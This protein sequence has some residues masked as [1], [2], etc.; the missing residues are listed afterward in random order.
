MATPLP[1]ASAATV[2]RYARSLLRRH[3]RAL[4][5]AL[6]LHALAAVAGLV[7]PRLL[8]DLVEAIERGT[9]ATTVDRVALLIV[10]FVVAQAVLTRVARLASAQLGERVLAEL[11]EDFIGRILAIGLSTVEKAGTGDLVTRVT[12][13]VDALSHSVRRAVPETL[14]A[15]V[16]GGFVVGALMLVDPLLALPCLVAVPV[17]WCGTRWYLRRA[18]AAYLRENATWAVV[19]D[20]LQETVDGAR[21]VDVLRRERHRIARTDDHLRL[22]GEAE[23]ASLR[24]RT[25]WF[26]IIEIGYVVPVAATL[27]I[28]GWFHLRGWVTL[29]AV[30]AATLYVQQLIDPID[31]LLTWLDELQVGAAS[32]ARLLGVGEVAAEERSATARPRSAR[33]TASGVRFA[34]T[35]GRDVLRGIDLTIEPG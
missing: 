7:A 1:V 5:G 8:G 35:P 4:G 33:I 19:T 11:R 6:A 3:P 12:R 27:L 17:L 28:G 14:I 9:A 2:R 29:G 20:G 23:K 34:Y 32:L 21:T 25:V 18:P 13:D 31:R 26:P 10:G 24:L 15:L 30:I 22:S 16:T